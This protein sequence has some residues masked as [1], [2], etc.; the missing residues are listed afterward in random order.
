MTTFIAVCLGLIVL[1]LGVLVAALAYAALKVQK[2]AQAVEVLTYRVEEQVSTFGNGIHSGWMK[3]LQV[4]AS[5]AG[6]IWRG[7]RS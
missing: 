3:A 6:G 1:E 5:L 2:T 4:G 7:R